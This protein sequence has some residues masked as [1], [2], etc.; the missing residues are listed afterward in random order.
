M[1]IYISHSTSFNYQGE[2]YEPFER[3]FSSSHELLFPHNKSLAQ[4]QAKEL[5]KTNGCEV[6]IAEVTLPSIGMGIELGWANMFEIPI[7]CIHKE[8]SAPSNSLQLITSKFIPYKDISDIQ[9]ELNSMLDE[10]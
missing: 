9:V 7:I 2:L 3:M 6:V 5:F 8:D 4:F 10:L 1:K